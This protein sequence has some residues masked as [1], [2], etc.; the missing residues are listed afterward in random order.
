MLRGLKSVIAGCLIVAGAVLILGV[1]GANDCGQHS[2]ELNSLL[3]SG[4]GVTA[5]GVLVSKL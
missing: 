5:L 3:W 1:A 4:L 2:A